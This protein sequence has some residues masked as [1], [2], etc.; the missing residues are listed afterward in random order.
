MAS[1]INRVAP[2]LALAQTVGFFTPALDDP[3]GDGRAA[4]A[5]ALSDV[6]AVGGRPVT[7]LNI[8]GAG[9]ARRV[10]NAR[11]GVAAGDPGVAAVI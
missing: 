7:A 4:A 9:S 6:Y 11:W 8:R 2:D 5:K 1:G 10:G 3:Y